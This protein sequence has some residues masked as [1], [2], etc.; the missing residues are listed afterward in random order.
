MVK[1]TLHLVKLPA[2]FDVISGG[3]LDLF[4]HLLLQ[5]FDVAAQVAV[6][7]VDADHNAALA[8]IA[9]DERWPFDH[10]HSRQIF[11]RNTRSVR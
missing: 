1:G 3:H 8:H 7:H 11:Q 9:I 5:F 10:L 4:F 6:L 2:Q